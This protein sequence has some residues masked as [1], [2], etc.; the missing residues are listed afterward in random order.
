MPRG[1]P[2]R[3][4][5]QPCR[6][7]GESRRGTLASAHASLHPGGPGCSQETWPEMIVADTNVIAYLLMP[8][9]FTEQARTAYETDPNWVAPL[10]WRSELRNVLVTAV[11]ERQLPLHRAI[12]LMK[13]AIEL[14]RH[15]EY[16]VQSEEVLR[17]AEES[18]CSAY[19]CEFVALSKEL[20]IP[21]VTADKRLAKAFGPGVVRLS[22]FV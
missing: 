19:D 17:L 2:A 3:K 4:T 13:L 7:V 20:R 22:E 12:E 15:G 5:C 10:L 9:D 16:E 1:G 6:D 18:G 21:L 8:G 11:R 14:M